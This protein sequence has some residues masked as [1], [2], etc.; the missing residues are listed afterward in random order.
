MKLFAIGDSLTQGFMSGA[1]A[2][3]HQSYVKLVA[4]VLQAE[5]FNVCDHWPRGGIPQNF[6]EL[7]RTLE[8][9]FG[10]DISGPL[11]WPLAINTISNFLDSIEEYWETGEGRYDLRY[12]KPH[13]YFHNSAIWGFRIADAWNLNA[14]ISKELILKDK[15]SQGDGWFALPSAAFYRTVNRMLN[16]QQKPECDG[17]SVLGWLNEHVTNSKLSGNKDGVEN[18]IVW[19]G[20]NNVLGTAL[21]LKPNQTTAIKKGNKSYLPHELSHVER[22]FLPNG[23]GRKWNLWR[24][25]HF[26][27]EYGELI[28]RIDQ[29]MR[30]NPADVDWKVFVANVPHVTIIPLT[31]GMGEQ[32]NII[33]KDRHGKSKVRTYFKYYGYFFLEEQDLRDAWKDQYLT[34]QDAIFIDDTIDEYNNLIDEILVEYNKAHDKPRYFLTDTNDALANMAW[35]RNQGM[36]TYKLPDP[37]RLKYPPVNTKY[38]NAAFDGKKNILKDGGIFSLDGV[39]PTAIGQGVIAAEFLSVM[40]KA[41]VLNKAGKSVSPSSLNWEGPQ[42]IIQSDTLYQKPI[43]LVKEIYQHNEFIDLFKRFGKIF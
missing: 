18:L 8:K 27:A 22:E 6:E 14:K 1:A 7:F 32:F 26:K 33:K 2:Q 12:P 5:P 20:N 25:N 4:D 9:R 30:K 37:I 23:E 31:K 29:T 17:L 40:S 28:K 35:K 16:P 43:A 34:L 21:S 36:P 41:G 19:L 24:P 10:N 38:Y 42:G 11:E 13:D 15:D 3:A 39:H